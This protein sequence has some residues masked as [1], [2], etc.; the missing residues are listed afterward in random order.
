MR[1]W[2]PFSERQPDE[3]LS[4]KHDQ[5]ATTGHRSQPASRGD[6]PSAR[7]ASA[8]GTRLST[9]QSLAGQLI[10]Q[11]HEKAAP[12]PSSRRMTRP[13]P[14]TAEP[15]MRPSSTS[16]CLRDFTYGTPAGPAVI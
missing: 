5:S 12:S 14:G 1:R 4:D 2:D 8:G 10:E 11:L 7:Q 15:F 9:P 13:A 16:L 3:R 6:A